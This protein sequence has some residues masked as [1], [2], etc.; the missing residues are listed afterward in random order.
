MD[1][2]RRRLDNDDTDDNGE[3]EIDEE[4]ELR[5]RG[6]SD[7][8]SSSISRRSSSNGSGASSFSSPENIPCLSEACGLEYEFSLNWRDNKLI[9]APDKRAPV[10]YC[11]DY[12]GFDRSTARKNDR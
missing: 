6:G 9:F 12:L 7:S 10:A 5:S 1:Q 4:G 11:N 2:Q 8:S 3:D